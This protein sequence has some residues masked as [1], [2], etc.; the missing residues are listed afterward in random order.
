R[1]YGGFKVRINSLIDMAKKVPK[2]GWTM[3]DGTPWPGNNVRDHPGM[4]QI[5][6]VMLKEMSYLVWCMFLVRKDQALI[7]IRKQGQCMLCFISTYFFARLL[8]V[9][10]SAIIS[11]AP[12]FLNVDCDHYINNDEGTRRGHAR[13]MMDPI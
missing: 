3:Q 12:Y 5:A 6:S 9:R 8:K 7:T 11:N 4:I 1:E 13:F 10:V 2:E